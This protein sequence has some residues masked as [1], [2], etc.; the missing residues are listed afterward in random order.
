M[1]QYTMNGATHHDTHLGMAF[2]FA[3]HPPLSRQPSDLSGFTPA[4]RADPPT[5]M[6]PSADAQK[7]GIMTLLIF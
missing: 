2:P 3:N 6:C 5:E 7:E 1:G 4:W